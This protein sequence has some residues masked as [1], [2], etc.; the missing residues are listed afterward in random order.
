[1]KI[2]GSIVVALAT[3]VGSSQTS[4]ALEIKQPPT[5]V[6]TKPKEHKHG[7]EID[8]KDDLTK[9]QILKTLN[10]HT[11]CE[12]LPVSPSRNI[13]Y[14]RLG[15]THNTPDLLSKLRKTD[16]IES[17]QISVVKP[18]IVTA[19]DIARQVDEMLEADQT[20]YNLSFNFKNYIT[21]E[22]AKKILASLKATNIELVHPYS[23][24]Y[25]A[26]IKTSLPLKEYLERVRQFSSFDYVD[27]NI[28][29]RSRF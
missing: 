29:K 8:F 6:Q 21:E 28:P 11:V 18:K 25:Q 22:G 3:L 5:Q 2:P 1:M 26:T 17:A 19:A 24:T 14:V 20:E 10:G 16:G 15:S 27:L 23:N 7:L 13:F 4:S 9:D 12:M